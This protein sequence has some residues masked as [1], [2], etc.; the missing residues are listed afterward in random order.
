MGGQMVFLKADLTQDKDMIRVTGEAAKLGQIRYLVNTA[1]FNYM[2]PNV[3][4][5]NQSCYTQNQ[6][7]FLLLN[8]LIISLMKTG[9]NGGGVIANIVQTHDNIHSFVKPGYNVASSGLQ[10][11]AR[12]AGCEGNGNIRSF[13]VSAHQTS[14]KDAACIMEHENSGRQDS[15]S[16]FKAAMTS[17]T[18][19]SPFEVANMI[20]YGFSRH[21]RYFASADFFFHG[22]VT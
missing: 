14:F 11:L 16:H 6:R 20:I 5:A 7:A 3:S 17:G 22:N 4:S 10:D 1:D 15:K 12:S 9:L 2:D 19:I 8:G 18:M 21:S 13:T